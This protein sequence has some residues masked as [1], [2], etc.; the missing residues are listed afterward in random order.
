MTN[1][2]GGCKCGAIEFGGEVDV[3]FTANC[4]CT[5]CQQFTGAAFATLVFVSEDGFAVQGDVGEYRHE[6]DRGSILTKTFCPVCGSPLFSR[7]T[8]RAGLV[9]VRIGAI[10]DNHVYP[11]ARNIYCTS[12]LPSTAMDPAI[13]KFDKMPG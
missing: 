10:R 7:N 2:K 6:S 3:A 4:H 5:D 9:G 8:A 1:L 13:P 12:A 11:P